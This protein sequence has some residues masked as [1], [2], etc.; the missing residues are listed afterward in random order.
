ML[1]PSLSFAV[2]A[3]LTDDAYISSS[4][5]PTANYGKKTILSVDGVGGQAPL[6]TSFLKFDLST[7]PAGV[8]GA[9]VEKATLKLFA[10]K[11]ITPGLFDVME[12]KSDWNEASITETTAPTVSGV[13][14]TG[15]PVSKSMA[16]V[17][18]DLTN[19]VMAWIDGTT[20]NYGIAIVPSATLGIN[21]NF[22]SKESTT[23]SHPASLEI[24]LT[25]APGQQ[26][27]P[28]PSGPSGP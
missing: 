11:L 13:V 8:T 22:D 1:L 16:F 4:G 14:A 18:V 21:V 5:S 25:E 24:G 23:T 17:T 19:L 27:P 6:K 3:P 12:V 9:D 28:G 15:V 2:E 10:P 7:L 20:P 26:G